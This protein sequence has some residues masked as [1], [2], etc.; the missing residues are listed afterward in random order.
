MNTLHL[1][2]R[3]LLAVALLAFA[4]SIS[5]A[6]N[7]DL[8][9][10]K[11]TYKRPTE[12]PFPEKAPYSLQMATL[13]K[14]LFYEPRLS[15][16]QNMNCATCHNPSFGYEAPVAKIIGAANTPLGR[17]APTILNLAW[18]TDLFWDG[19]ATSL[20]E[21]AAGPITAPVEMNGK[22]DEI[23]PR[24]QNID[25]YQ[26]WFDELFPGKGITRDTILTAIATYERTVLSGTAPFDRWVDGDEDAI[27]V[28]AKRGFEL[29]IGKAQCANCHSGWNFTDNKFYDV[30]MPDDDIGRG[31]YEPDNI[32]AQQAFKT[33]GL[34]NLTYRA[35]YMHDG[36]LADLASVIS[37]YESGG[38]ERPSKSSKMT[39][40]SLSED[41]HNDLVAF[42][43]ALT[44][45]KTETPI[46]VLPN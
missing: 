7:K 21:Q 31:K 40:F 16:A 26:E 25:L 43:T 33:P 35:P 17:Q 5:L 4:N 11:Q 46:P 29:F 18:T 37:H 42:L 13:G 34:R 27:S 15:G 36:S 12:I 45:E 23:V 22:F 2:G 6:E 44:A 38:I 10:V 1:A 8:S 14:M 28:S 20:E 30:G 9:A 19:R 39:S 32:A 41:E 24:L 3:A